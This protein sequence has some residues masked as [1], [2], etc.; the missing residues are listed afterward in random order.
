MHFEPICGMLILVKK[1]NE[2][3]PNRGHPRFFQGKGIVIN[4]VIM[5]GNQHIH[6][7]RGLE[8][9]RKKGQN[10]ERVF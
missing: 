4:K 7:P 10:H 1:T 3:V 5:I 6:N 2:G 8:K 9:F